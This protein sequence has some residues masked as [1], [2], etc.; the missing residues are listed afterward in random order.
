[1]V[2]SSLPDKGS[3]GCTQ[4]LT[5]AVGITAAAVHGVAGGEG[6]VSGSRP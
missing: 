6:G 2:P 4:S 5:A 1:M 3:L